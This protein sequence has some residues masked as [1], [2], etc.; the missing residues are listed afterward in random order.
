MKHAHP[1]SVVL[2]D[3]LCSRVRDGVYRPG[4]RMPGEHA[5]AREFKLNRLTVR[6]AM[7]RLRADG[8]V[9]TVH[10]WGSVVVGNPETL[11]TP[12]PKEKQVG[13]VL[14]FWA[15]FAGRASNE[16]FL[17]GAVR[18]GMKHGL[19]I[20][21]IF[22]AIGE[23]EDPACIDKFLARHR[24]GLI[25]FWPKL[26]YAASLRRLAAARLPTVL[27][28]RRFDALGFPAVALNGR[29]YGHSVIEHLRQL[30]HERIGIIGGSDLDPHFGGLIRGLVDAARAAGIR[31][32][33]DQILH[34][35]DEPNAEELVRG[36]LARWVGKLTALVLLTPNEA[37]ETVR[38]MQ[39]LGYRIPDDLGLVVFNHGAVDA[40]VF[41]D[42]RPF[43][44]VVAP[45]DQIGERS[46]ELLLRKWQEPALHEV[47][48]LP[49]TVRP[50]ESVMPA[51]AMKGQSVEDRARL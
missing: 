29:A 43:T 14:P 41:W 45:L 23:C 12:V 44:T 15:E 6:K 20:E 47:M 3:T 35:F 22:T 32:A 19:R 26:E 51:A 10:G 18:C 13:I 1:P 37:L 17:Q 8:W 28:L 33:D 7:A 50:G 30:G 11:R 24:D 38:W 39:P 31:I 21:P 46:V 42:G 25:W 16:T 27:A 36:Y 48:L 49:A 5:L 40:N 4:Q 9:Q 2:L 34:S